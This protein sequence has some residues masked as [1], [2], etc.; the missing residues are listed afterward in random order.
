MIAELSIQNFALIENGHFTL[1]PGLN[2][3]TG[4][5][6]AGKSIILGAINLL[7]GGRPSPELIRKG[8]TEASV[9]ARFSFSQKTP[10]TLN[11]SNRPYSWIQLRL[12]QLGIEKDPDHELV[13]RRQISKNSHGPLKSR[14]YVNGH[15]INRSSLL[16][17]SEGLIDLCGQ[18]EHQILLNPIHHR[19]ILDRMMNKETLLEAMKTTYLKFQ[20]IYDQWKDLT[21]NQAHFIQKKDYLHH[22]IKEI[23]QINPSPK[24]EET[25]SQEIKK[26]AHM[27]ELLKNIHSSY[28]LLEDND[29]N[30]TSDLRDALNQMQ[31]AAQLDPRFLQ[32]TKLLEEALINCQETARDLALLMDSLEAN[33]DRLQELENRLLS[34]HN[35]YKKHGCDGETIIEKFENMKLEYDK[36]NFSDDHL[37]HLEKN[38]DKILKKAI[39]QSL[40]LHEER[41]KISSIL[42]KKIKNEL[43]HLSLSKA[44]IKVNFETFSPKKTIF[45]CSP[46]EAGISIFGKD[47]LHFLFAPNEGEGYRALH[48]IAS[49]G[50]L[51]RTLLAIKCILSPAEFTGTYLFDEIDAGIGGQTA[52]ALGQKLKS[53][54]QKRQV[55]CITHLPQIACFADHHLHVQKETLKGRTRTKIRPLSKEERVEEISRML[56]GNQKS[57]ISRKHALE[58]L[59][60]CQ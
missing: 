12:D 55:L 39:Q 31:I 48:Q 44:K 60:Q 7:L 21:E 42:E 58:M 40:E 6:G 4:E 35:L 18:R 9:E 5:T 53:L 54:S 1:E 57:S 8:C 16:R 14:I 15:M 25:L 43:I 22:Q 24:E 34:L 20:E 33:P 13:I 17:L 49:G 11:A 47:Q 26:L 32:S 50:E 56:G 2:V 10:L 45:P 3:L 29:Q 52:N 59:R 46:E 37:K 23:E 36:I 27:E 19:E 38:G 41:K 30:I 28:G 51:S